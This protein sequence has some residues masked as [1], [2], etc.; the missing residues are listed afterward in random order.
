M[1]PLDPWRRELRGLIPRGFLRRV[2][3]DGLFAS[4]YPRFAGAEDV[5][6]ALL[7]AGYRVTVEG[8]V[9]RI[10]GN[11]AKYHALF[12]NLPCPDIVP[13]DETLYAVSLAR[14]LIRA[15]TPEDEE[16]LGGYPA[17]LKALDEGNWLKA[18]DETAA[19][20]AVCQRQGRK[21][22]SAAGKLILLTLSTSER[23]GEKSPC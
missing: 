8:G 10:D 22:P 21:P 20:A 13:D 14:R 18:T 19:W 4:D 15:N 17:L 1:S 23:K 12:T 11:E 7:R 2:Q 9:A 16:P 3:G 6:A 5:T